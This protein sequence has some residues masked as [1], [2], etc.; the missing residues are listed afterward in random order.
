MPGAKDTH[1]NEKASFGDL[2]PNILWRVILFG[3]KTLV[4]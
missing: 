3:L 1:G 2:K 4:L